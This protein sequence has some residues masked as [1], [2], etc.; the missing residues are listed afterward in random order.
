MTRTD[1]KDGRGTG[2]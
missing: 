2:I 1:S